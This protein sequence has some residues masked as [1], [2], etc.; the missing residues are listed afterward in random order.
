MIKELN[1]RKNFLKIMHILHVF[2]T[3]P[4]ACGFRMVL[5]VILCLNFSSCREEVAILPPDIIR[6]AEPEISD[7]RGFYLLNEGN[8]G[9]NKATLDYFDFFTGNYHINIF[10]NANPNV[11]KEL[12]DVGNDLAIYGSKMYAVLNAS[13]K[14]EVMNRHTAKRVGQIDIPN[15]RYI[16]FHA[17][18][19]YI[20]SYAGPIEINPNY[21]Q[22]GFVAKVDTATFEIIDRCFVG[23]QPDGIEITDNK[24]YVANSGG[25]VVPNYENTVSVIDI[26]SFKEIKRIEVAINLHRLQLDKY[27]VLWVSSRGDY[28]EQTSKLHWIDTKTDTYGGALDVAVSGMTLD[29]DSLYIF[30]ADF[31]LTTTFA[32]VDVSKKEIVTRNFLANGA[33]NEFV[34]P[35][36]IM[37]NPRNKDIYITDASNYVHPGMLFC[38]DRHGN[39]KWQVRTGDIP[40][41]FAI[42][43]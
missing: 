33:E 6:V 40:A 2:K 23:F 28:F 12:G 20:T 24:I 4:L 41:H 32:I 29:G 42:L 15:C 30:S 8:M 31:N 17:G 18:Y 26:E 19:A 11:P 16:K 10:A 25:Y 27:G 1:S 39:K 34:R 35:Y 3:L 37:V 7:M 38:F 5:T 14:V 22:I 43:Y 36:G 21:T 9:S 13:N